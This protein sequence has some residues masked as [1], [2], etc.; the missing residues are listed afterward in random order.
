MAGEIV[1]ISVSIQRADTMF[2]FGIEG[3]LPSWW[4]AS[5]VVN[6]NSCIDVPRLE[7]GFL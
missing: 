4:R 3:Y 1:S 2:L 6:Y 5:Y 7:H